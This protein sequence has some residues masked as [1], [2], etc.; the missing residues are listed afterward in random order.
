MTLLTLWR[1]QADIP[2]LPRRR[3]KVGSN[4]VEQTPFL[5][6]RV[7]AEIKTCDIPGH[8]PLVPKLGA[9][10][11]RI[12]IR[13]KGARR[14]DEGMP[15]VTAGSESPENFGE[16]VEL[17][18]DGED[19]LGNY[20]ATPDAVL[21]SWSGAFQFKTEDVDQNL[22]GLRAPQI[23]ALHAIAAHFAVGTQFEP[24]TVVL[25]TGTGKTERLCQNADVTVDDR[26]S[27]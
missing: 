9:P 1:G 26:V 14:R 3:I 12:L 8:D 21:V 13:R 22:K 2:A 11:D 4:V 18:W 25:P 17:T 6:L 23:G 19:P 10:F 27:I 5:G 7:A 24:A 15:V 20:V 16:N